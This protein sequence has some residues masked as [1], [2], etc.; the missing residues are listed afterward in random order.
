MYQDASSTDCGTYNIRTSFKKKVTAPAAAER[1]P[2][3]DNI[4]PVY[5]NL[6]P[7]NPSRNYP[8]KIHQD[9]VY[10]DSR[11]RCDYHDAVNGCI[12]EY[13]GSI[14][15]EERQVHQAQSYGWPLNR[16]KQ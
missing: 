11:L 13:T 3:V 6:K 16:R 14:S 10:M 2:V 12:M 1:Q 9:L 15:D 7:S 5:P 4:Q 8:H